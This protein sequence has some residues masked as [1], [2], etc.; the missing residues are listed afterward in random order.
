MTRAD[1]APPSTDGAGAS[2]RSGHDTPRRAFGFARLARGRIV[3]LDLARFLA[4]IG[5][6]AAHVWNERLPEGGPTIALT[7]VQGRAAALFAVLAGVGIVLSMRRYLGGI[8]G[9]G[10]GSGGRNRP[11]EASTR[12]AASASAEVDPVFGAP[13]G[14]PAAVRA[15]LARGAAVMAIGLTLGLVDSG[16]AIILVFYGASFWLTIPFLR[17]HAGALVG[18]ALLWA[19]VWPIL[20]FGVRTVWWPST[21]FA[22]PSWTTLGDPQFVPDLFITGVYPVFTWIVYLLVGMAVG[23]LLLVARASAAEDGGR[24]LRRLALRLTFGGAA[25][26]LAGWALSALALGPFGGIDAI[27]QSRGFTTSSAGRDMVATDLQGSGFGLVP[28][29]SPWWLASSLAHSGATLDLV[30]TAGTGVAVIGLCLLAGFAVRGAGAVILAPIVA[31]GAAPLTIYCTHVLVEAATG[32]VLP[33]DAWMD[34]DLMWLMSSPQ[35]W[36]LHVAGAILI[37]LVLAVLGRRGP[38][39]T[40][41]TTLS[42]A[43]GAGLPRKRSDR[44]AGLGGGSGR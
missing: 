1:A 33:V 8:D 18:V 40:A 34:D 22:N 23:R 42:R 41:V 43:A 26:A 29:E 36:L 24:M 11:H 31:A 4:L 27:A 6:M 13:H 25:A 14:M 38:L 32:A 39:E 7:L 21:E 16:I 44:S 15:L 19:L 2:T 10:S 5:M 3:G 17:L 20:S 37:G 35:L 30:L 28:L 12:A 9:S